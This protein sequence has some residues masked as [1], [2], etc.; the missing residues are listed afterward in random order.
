MTVGGISTERITGSDGWRW[1]RGIRDKRLSGE[2]RTPWRYDSGLVCSYRYRGCPGGRMIP[3]VGAKGG[4]GGQ[5][6]VGPRTLRLLQT[7]WTWLRMVFTAG[8]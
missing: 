1:G 7:Y 4:I 6:N 2:K 5:G 8:G 3:C